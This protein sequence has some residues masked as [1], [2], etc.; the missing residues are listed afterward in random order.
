MLVLGGLIL[1]TTV[2]TTLAAFANPG[3]DEW[4]YSAIRGWA[5]LDAM[6]W[7]EVAGTPLFL[8]GLGAL[9]LLVALPDVSR[10]RRRCAG[11]R[12]PVGWILA[13]VVG[14]TRPV[15]SPAGAD[16]YPSS[17]LLLTVLAGLVPMALESMTRKVRVRHVA[18]TTLVLLDVGAARRSTPATAAGRGGRRTIGAGLVVVW[19]VSCS[20]NRRGIAGVARAC[21]RSALA[22]AVAPTIIETDPP[23][24]GSCTG[25]P[26]CGSPGWSGPS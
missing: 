10:R 20:R 26:C 16:S 17:I 14:R 18:T 2:A 11:G 9:V 13:T 15:E 3:A 23:G 5:W 24:P 6:S 1:T 8:A 4:L 25:R 19:P 21:G 12:L 22:P 7:L